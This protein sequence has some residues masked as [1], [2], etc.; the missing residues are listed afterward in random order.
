MTE[1]KSL[2]GPPTKLLLATD[3]SGRSDR[4]LDRAVQLARLWSAT[5]VVLHVL[6]PEADV[7][8]R[9]L[10]DVPSWRRPPDRTRA[11]AA[12]L[13]QDMLESAPDL[14][15]VVQEGDPATVVGEVAKR[16]GCGLIVT[17]VARDET[18]GRY[19]LGT[20]VDRL[21]RRS[22]IPVLIVKRRAKQP[23]RS[24]VAATDFSTPSRLALD[25]AAAFFPDAALAL[26]H[27]FEAPLAAFLGEEKASEAFREAERPA[28]EAFLKDSSLTGEQRARLRILIEE[29]QPDTLTRAYMEDNDV[30][31]VALGA[32][33]RS[34]AVETLIG[35]TAKR[36]I[37][38]A[39]GDVLLVRAPKAGR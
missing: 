12:R 20:T 11:A 30:D 38:A 7:Q 5:L 19:V 15:V 22:P 24:I 32:R 8:L 36:I 23:Y 10:R 35:G 13:R 28:C 6:E 9:E 1:P 39:P 33:G 34:A 2:I 29:G 21:V 27:A 26:L 14:K 16:E 37:Q 4:A 3:L 25:A 18:L 31:L 17:G